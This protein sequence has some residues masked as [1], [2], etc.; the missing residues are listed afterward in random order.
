MLDRIRFC[1]VQLTPIKLQVHELPRL[2]HATAIMERHAVTQPTN[3]REQ[4]TSLPPQHLS[5]AH[6]L[7]DSVMLSDPDTHTG[8]TL[9]PAC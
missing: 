9:Q 7:Q 6:T 8:F 1:L 3:S 2:T 5:Y 4:A